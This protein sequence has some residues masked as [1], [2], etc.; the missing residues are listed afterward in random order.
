LINIVT[1][2]KQQKKFLEI[3]SKEYAYK[4]PKTSKEV[5]LISKEYVFKNLECVI[6]DLKKMIIDKSF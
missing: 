2:I 3:T 5:F 4:F 6:D 1:H